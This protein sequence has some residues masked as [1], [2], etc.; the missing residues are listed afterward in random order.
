MKSPSATYDLVQLEAVISDAEAVAS[1]RAASPTSFTAASEFWRIPVEGRHLSSRMKELILLAMHAT[2]TALNVDALERHIHRARGAGA[3]DEDII[4]VLITIVAVANHA[5]YSSVPILEEELQAAGI[6][7]PD[8]LGPDS[9]FE[10]AKEEFIA[11]RGFW[12]PDRDRLARL[13]PDYFRVLNDISTVSWKNGPLSAKEREFVCIGIDCTVTHS[14]EPGLRRH[15]R[16]ALGHGATREE[17]LEIFQL[18]ALIGLEGYIIGA[19]ALFG[20]ADR[21]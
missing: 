18:A 6:V 16:N 15:I 14:Y 9:E 11:A 7:D 5:L 4:D 20:A 8:T 19:R 12:N 17:I 13:M 2:A 3:T 21:E 10:A 1:L